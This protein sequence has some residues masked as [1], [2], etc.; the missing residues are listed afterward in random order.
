MYALPFSCSADF[1]TTIPQSF[2]H[3]SWYQSQGPLCKLCT[4]VNV[5]S[6]CKRPMP[7]SPKP[8]LQPP[9]ARV[10]WIC[11]QSTTNQNQWAKC[12]LMLILVGRIPTDAFLIL[13][14]LCMLHKSI[15]K[16]Y[17]RISC[18]WTGLV[19]VWSRNSAWYLRWTHVLVHTLLAFLGR[20]D[21][22]I[23]CF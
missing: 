19:L 11:P 8:R 13:K 20:D 22:R 2:P 10:T 16:I 4:I 5:I 3:L 12:L 7:R 14:W 9:L 15:S 21:S 17:M 1:T 23:N 6:T 18:I